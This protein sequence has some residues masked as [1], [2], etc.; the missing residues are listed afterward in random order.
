MKVESIHILIMWNVV[1]YVG[2]IFYNIILLG[3]VY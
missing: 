2:N 3:I 1:Q